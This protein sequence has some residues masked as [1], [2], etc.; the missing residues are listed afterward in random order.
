MLAALLAAF[1]CACHPQ[2]TSDGGSS[3]T[4][5]TPTP[6]PEPAVPAF[7]KGADISWASEMEAGGIKFKKA[8]GTAAPLLDVLKSCGM[9]AIRLRVWVDPYKG[10]C[11]KDDVVAVAQKVHV[12]GMDLM[13]DFH[14]SDFFADPSRQ[15]IPA[16][17]VGDKADLSKMCAHVSSHTT[18]VLQALKGAGVPVK[19]V[20]IGNE[21]RNGMLYGTGDLVYA[22]KNAEFASYVRL[23]NAGYDAAKAVY[24]DAL[25]MPHIDNAFDASN[26]AWWFS[27]FKAQG[28]RF[29]MVA[30]SHY[31]QAGSLSAA[32]ANAKAVA[33]IRSA[34]ATL[35]VKVMVSEVGVKTPADEATAASVLKS[36]IDSVKDLD[37][38]AGVFYWEPEVYGGW[39]PAVYSDAAAIERYTGRR[40]TWNGYDMGAFTS[41]GTPSS[42]L[43]AF[44]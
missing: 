41:A 44:L 17:W 3:D 19:W 24:P 38:C 43:S 32:D 42:V 40:E 5:V 12:A 23:S 29:D 25:V 14:Y 2:A 1:S 20:Q 9:N 13:I 4:P 34:A 6:E 30:L 11:G 37:A 26:N 33:Y 35:G 28:G 36:F 16:A 39:K 8:D 18:E 21:T 15:L 27:Q 22:N 31:P 10:W 7:A